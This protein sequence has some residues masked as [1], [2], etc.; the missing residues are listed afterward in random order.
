MSLADLVPERFL[1][2]Q[3]IAVAHSAEHA[4]AAR[5]NHRDGQASGEETAPAKNPLQQSIRSSRGTSGPD[6]T[7]G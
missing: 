6:P 2:R 7:Y 4:A 5:P 1:S 3:T